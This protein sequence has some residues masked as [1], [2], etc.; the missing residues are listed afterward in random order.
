MGGSVRCRE[1]LTP[2]D[3]RSSL[4]VL[5]ERD[6]GSFP[7]GG[8]SLL[9]GNLGNRWRGRIGQTL[10]G[11]ECLLVGKKRGGHVVLWR[12]TCTSHVE[13]SGWGAR[14]FAASR[15]SAT[16]ASAPQSAGPAVEH[17]ARPSPPTSVASLSMNR[18]RYPQCQ[19]RQAC[20]PPHTDSP[21]RSTSIIRTRESAIRLPASGTVENRQ[22][23]DLERA[24]RVKG[25]HPRAKA[26][27]EGKFL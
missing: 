25:S 7:M 16:E 8:A 18:Y 12:T 26:G 24:G 13:M 14:R 2:E 27:S 3:D 15:G 9:A 1:S 23:N 6:F 19:K 20:H 5:H 4:T 22:F 11:H 10:R 21:L 17:A